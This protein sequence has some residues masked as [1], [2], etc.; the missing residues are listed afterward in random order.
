MT[1]LFIDFKDAQGQKTPKLGVG[2]GQNLDSLK[3]SCISLFP[4]LE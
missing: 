1:A 4:T 3:L 2:S